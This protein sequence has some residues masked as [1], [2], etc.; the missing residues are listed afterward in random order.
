MKQVSS[1]NFASQIRSC[2]LPTLAITFGLQFIRSFIPGL[3]WYLRDTVAVGTMSLIPYAF[4][5]FALGFIAPLVRRLLG[6]RSALWITA[7]SLALLRIG[8]QIC[9]NPGI[10]LWLNIAGVGL[11]LNFIPIFI[12]CTRESSTNSSERWTYGL[13]L[14]F[15]LD[16]GLRGIFGPRDLSTVAGIIPLVIIIILAGM[17]IWG[18]VQEPKP[19]PGLKCDTVGKYSLGLL[20]IGSYMVLQ[21]LYFQSSGWVEEVAGLG[22]P[23]GFIIVML[24]YLVA[25][26]GLG[27]GYARPRLLHPL[28][29]A[30]FGILLVYT[31]FNANQVGDFAILMLLIGQFFLGWGLAGIGLSNDLGI[32]QGLWHTTLAVIGGLVLFLALSFAY[33][34]ALDMTLPFPRDIFPTIAAGILGILITV[35]A[36]Q[37]RARSSTSWDHT[38]TISAGILAMI[39]LVCWI[40]WR[41]PPAPKQPEGFPVKVM[42]YNIH[43]GYNVDG[44]QDF[45][46]IAQVIEESGADIIGMQEVSRVRLMDGAVDMTTWLSR[47]LGMQVLFLGTGEPTWGN[48]LLS[49]YPIIESGKGKLPDEGTPI[50]RGYLWAKIDV[51][52]DEPL[53][54]IVTH[55]HQV[56]VD[57]QIRMV[58][59]PVI[60]DFWDNRGQTVFLGDLNAEPNSEEIKL[61]SRVGLIDS[62]AKSGVGPGYTY[63]ATDPYK[64]IDYLWLSPDLEVREIEVIQSP[65]SDHLPVLGEFDLNN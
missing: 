6:T 9:S 46:A 3:A 12:G 58:Q 19:S 52:E 60:L 28:L 42:N 22:F 10:D 45:E 41:T 53:L 24:G 32:K 29:A 11:F 36:S 34:L 18:L 54:V 8:E 48:A 47:R 25:A 26:R 14:G 21:L 27:L 44:G 7:G 57:S 49:R 20:V 5:T 61:I 62:W 43:S 16:T 38:G 40:F 13:I 4:G 1:S 15:A 56:V 64:R 63:Y 31:V 35:G 65:A 59:V 2:L 50:K 37:N 23:Y 51:G 17:L 55:L 30:G 39:P 33:Y